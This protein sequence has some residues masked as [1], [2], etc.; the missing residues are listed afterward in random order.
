M[1]ETVDIKIFIT[2]RDTDKKTLAIYQKTSG[3]PARINKQ[4]WVI[5][6]CR[7]NF[8]I[9]AKMVRRYINLTGKIVKS[10]N[11]KILMPWPN[12]INFQVTFFV[13]YFLLPL[14]L[15]PLLVLSNHYLKRIFREGLDDVDITLT[16]NKIK[17]FISPKR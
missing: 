1:K 2:S 17:Y 4:N 14:L 10:N 3:P 11:R 7:K 6:F 8:L 13:P 15:L 12:K 16:V 5:G 9:I